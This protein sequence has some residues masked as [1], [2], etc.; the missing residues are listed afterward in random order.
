MSTLG[1]NLSMFMLFMIIY[2]NCSTNYSFRV[3]SIACEEENGLMNTTIVIVIKEAAHKTNS[4]ILKHCVGLLL[5]NSLQEIG[6]GQGCSIVIFS[7]IV[8]Y[9][10]RIQQIKS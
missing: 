2:Q 9:G 8:M 3:S 6:F 7:L 5:L 4:I 1:D 10:Q